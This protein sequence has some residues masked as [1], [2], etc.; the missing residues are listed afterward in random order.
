MANIDINTVT[1]DDILRV[2][3][4]RPGCGCGC[5]GK[6]RYNPKHKDEATEDAGSTG[7]TKADFNSVQ[8]A[9]VLGLMK[10]HAD[11]LQWH[12]ASIVAWE[13]ETRYYWTYFTQAFIDRH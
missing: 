8:V 13:T 7:V 4:G 6:Y 1:T 3:S 12:D 10:Q 5:R 11:E 9:K 2:Y